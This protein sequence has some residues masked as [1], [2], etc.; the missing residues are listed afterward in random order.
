ML[1]A[2]FS[3]LYSSL[4]GGGKGDDNQVVETDKG[5]NSNENSP[6]TSLDS[7][8]AVQESSSDTFNLISP[9]IEG[10][11]NAYENIL[12]IDQQ[13]QILINQSKALV[14][15]TAKPI[16]STPINT[17][18]YDLEDLLEL[19][20]KKTCENN[21]ELVN[22]VNQIKTGNDLSNITNQ[23]LANQIKVKK[24]SI[25]GELLSAIKNKQ[26]IDNEITKRNT[27]N[28]ETTSKPEKIEAP[29]TS[30]TYKF[31]RCSTIYSIV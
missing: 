20:I 27:A 24:D 1:G 16:E 28:Y 30:L 10:E 22:L 7:F 12:K 18:V 5:E 23:L 31:F 17:K 4:F 14:D 9:S 8:N 11:K 13:S 21:D 2:I 3:K 15:I 6:S 25:Y 29:I 26:N 19:L